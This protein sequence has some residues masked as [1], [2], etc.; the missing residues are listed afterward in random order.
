MKHLDLSYHR[1][2]GPGKPESIYGPIPIP[3]E[4]ML[5]VVKS[6]TRVVRKG[7]RVRSSLTVRGGQRIGL[8][9]V[10]T[11]STK[12]PG[13]RHDREKSGGL[14]ECSIHNNVE[15]K[16]VN[17]YEFTEGT[18]SVVRSPCDSSCGYRRTRDPRTSVFLLYLNLV[19]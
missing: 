3:S 13:S 15:G 11:D 4:E 16:Q 9:S 19:Y 14:L 12:K 2:R 1:I 18:Q 6:G 8:L 10:M 17:L 5:T 7:T